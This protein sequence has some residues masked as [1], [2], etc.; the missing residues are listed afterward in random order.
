MHW[1]SVH[2]RLFWALVAFSVIAFVGTLIA[3]PWMVVRIPRDYFRRSIIRATP[4]RHPVVHALLLIGK[5]VLGVVFI[6]LGI[7][8]LVL[9]G[10]GL[11]TILAG[12]ALIDFPG[13]HRLIGLLVA[14]PAVLKSMNW[15][16]QRAGREPLIV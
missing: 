15:I 13:K 4:R 10:Q 3:V 14:Q 7:L 9:P 8:M 11:L 6:L 1:V 12:A 5:N 16:R 2:E